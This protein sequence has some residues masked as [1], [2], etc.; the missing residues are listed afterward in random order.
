MRN[1]K[2]NARYIKYKSIRIKRIKQNKK[3]YAYTG[4]QKQ[5]YDWGLWGGESSRTELADGLEI[6]F[7]NWGRAR[8]GRGEESSWVSKFL[9]VRRE[10]STLSLRAV[11]LKDWSEP[12]IYCFLFSGRGESI[13]N[14]S[15]FDRRAKREINHTW[16]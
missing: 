10:L 4:M 12:F 15:T 7:L 9:R 11:M 8:K 3:Q 1:Q 2:T 13:S 14:S 16:I 5:Q 6:I